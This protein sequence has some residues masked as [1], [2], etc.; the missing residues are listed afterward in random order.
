MTPSPL[1]RASWS[2]A[3]AGIALG[4]FAQ[5]PPSSVEQ[6]AAAQDKAL[7]ESAFSKADSNGDGKLTPEEA[8]KLPAIA[9]R[10]DLL[11]KDKDGTLSLE[12]FAAGFIAPD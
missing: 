4:A 3:V 10:F 11:D 1:A 7:V 5:T 9:A 8:S 6:P 12:E 2:V